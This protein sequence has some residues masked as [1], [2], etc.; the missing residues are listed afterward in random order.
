MKQ[1]SQHESIAIVVALAVVT[2]TF[3]GV[4]TNLFTQGTNTAVPAKDT[5]VTID[6]AND[7]NGASKALAE[8]MDATG[9]VTD[10]LIEDTTVGT[11][12]EVKKGDT[13]S[14]HYVGMLQDGT[15]FDDSA[16]RGE[17]FVF[18]V[19]VGSVI[20]GWDKGIIGMRVGGERVLVIPASMA[21]GERGI[22]VVPPNATLL[23]AI[24]LLEVK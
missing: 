10:L 5:P 24:K 16:A 7:P 1:L 11:G 23:F 8:A 2:A 19:G 22:G 20:P 14:V 6:T 17:P 15:R 18:T 12:R 21:Y 9:A 4:F 13:V 3:F